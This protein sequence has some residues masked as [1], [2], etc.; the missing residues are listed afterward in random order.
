MKKLLLVTLLAAFAVTTMAGCG[1]M[2]AMGGGGLLYQNTRAPLA[3]V[4]YY[5]PTTTGVAKMGEA[6]M[7]SFLGLIIT[8]D[9]SIKRAMEVGGITQIHHI[10]TEM[11]NILGIIATYKVIVY[12]E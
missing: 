9:A 10:D 12:G 6:S 5:G 4:S 11:T 8:G 1:A 7:Q 3:S 2:I